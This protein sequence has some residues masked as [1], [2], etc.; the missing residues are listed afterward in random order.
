MTK[1]LQ[2]FMFETGS[3]QTI[4]IV[5]VP[6]QSMAN[7]FQSEVRFAHAVDILFVYSKF[8]HLTY[9]MNL[10]NDISKQGIYALFWNK[11]KGKSCTW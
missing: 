6:F 10:R 5:N 2:S 3:L 11:K 8:M 4:H 7:G 9:R 1:A